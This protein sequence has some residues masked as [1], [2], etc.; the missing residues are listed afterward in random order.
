MSNST[1]ISKIWSSQICCKISYTSK[2]TKIPHF[3]YILIHRNS[4][5]YTI[6]PQVLEY[7][8]ISHSKLARA[9]FEDIMNQPIDW[10]LPLGVLYDLNLHQHMMGCFELI[11]NI[12]AKQPPPLIGVYLQQIKQ[13]NG[14][15]D[16]T[17]FYEKFWRNLV[18]ESCYILNGSSNII[19]SMS[20]E[21]SHSF[22][23]AVITHQ[24]LV[25]EKFVKKIVPAKEKMKN[26]PVKLY[27]VQNNIILKIIQS[28]IHDLINDVPVYEIKIGQLVDEVI[29]KDDDKTVN[30]YSQG[31]E[32]SQ[33]A[34]ID[35][36]YSIMKYF[37][38]FLHIV[39]RV[40]TT[41]K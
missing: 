27:I 29:E 38:T 10:S 20:M 26:L 19:M 21:N 22:W 7:F 30:L 35:E 28:N 31:I 13:M 1:I 8:Q 36:I 5:I 18:K 40:C 6:I 33:D 4:Y 23:D 11:L 9:W 12:D 17:H 24:G 16:I 32:I 25:F 3:Y 34:P 15:I 37:D 14:T 2:S 39:I 41:T